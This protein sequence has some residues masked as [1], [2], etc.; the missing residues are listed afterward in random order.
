M[1]IAAL[2]FPALFVLVL[3]GIPI[4]LSL[5]VVSAGAGFMVFGENVFA[6][7]YG[8]FYSAATNFILAAIPMFVLMGAILERS[9]IAER[10]FK[11]MQLWLGRLPGGL[12]VATIAMGAVFAAAAGVVG[13]VEVMIGMM[14]I[15]A[16]QRFRYSNSLTAGTI[17]AGGSLGTMIPPSVIAVMYASLAQMSVGE[18]LAAMMF[19]GLLMIALFIAFIILHGLIWPPEKT[20]AHEEMRAV[21][22]KDKLQLTLTSLLPIFALIVAVLGSLLAGVASPTEAASLGALGAILLCIAYGRFS[23]SMLREALTIT[24]RISAMILLI[25]AA[26]TMFMGTFA[27]NGGSKLIRNAV[28]AAGLGEAGIIIFFLIIV[29]LLGFVLDWTANV[30]ICVP[31]FT[32]IIRQAGIDPVW[33]GTMVIIVIQ[34]SYL[35]PPMASSIF[36][37]KSIAP[38]DMTYGQMCKGVVPF[39]ALQIVTLLVVALFPAIATWLPDQIVGF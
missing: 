1:S 25:V 18:L 33:F 6:Q 16:M 2:M 37:L 32:P 9:G 39:I 8:S 13:A 3:V 24:V 30:L 5:T 12:A 31:L 10:L 22:L 35:T 29:F 28:E 17:C 26:G 14:A 38:P 11:V 27:A 21:P 36:Y 34:T 7:L 20:D 19:P 15:P 4:S 23:L